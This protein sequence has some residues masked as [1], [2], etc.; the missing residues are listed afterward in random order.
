MNIRRSARFTPA[1]RALLVRRVIQ[2]GWTA[3]GAA[4][5]A[6]VSPRTAYEWL[7]RLDEEGPERL[8]DWSS[9][10]KNS[11]TQIPADWQ[12]LVVELRRLRVTGAVIVKRL[13]IPRPTVARILKRHGL[14]RMMKL[15]PPV[16]V[17]R[18]E[19][20]GPGEFVHLD[21]KRPGRLRGV[22]HSITGERTTHKR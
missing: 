11:P 16:P 19:K 6:V 20:T 18:Y 22:G 9:R 14:E 5:A 15:E 10:P 7:W 4:E 21:I 8:L 3:A 13:G 2:E 1:G 17:G 12:K